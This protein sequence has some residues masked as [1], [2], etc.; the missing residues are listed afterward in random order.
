MRLV[1]LIAAALAAGPALAQ[2]EGDRSNPAGVGNTPTGDAA[3]QPTQGV[4]LRRTLPASAQD[5]LDTL[6]E[7]PV[8]TYT[9]QGAQGVIDPGAPGTRAGGI[10]FAVSDLDRDGLIS[11]LEFAQALEPDPRTSMPA[12]EAGRAVAATRD[13]FRRLDADRNARLSPDEL[14][15]R[16]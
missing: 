9:I 13:E 1:L 4:V 3:S 12:T 2:V 14:R 10:D 15:A 16:R 6:P 5:N 11:P 7:Q 8:A